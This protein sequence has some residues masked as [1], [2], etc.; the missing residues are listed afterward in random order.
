MLAVDPYKFNATVY[1]LR[2]KHER[3]QNNLKVTLYKHEFDGT[4]AF[5]ANND[6]TDGL[7]IADTTSTS[8]GT[9]NIDIDKYLN[10]A[11]V[12]RVD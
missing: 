10:N 7:T 2:L 4:K 11:R 6:G 8:A 9:F 3:V 5:D 12:P 1:I